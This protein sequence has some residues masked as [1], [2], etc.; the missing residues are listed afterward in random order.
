MEHII[1]MFHKCIISLHQFTWQTLSQ[2]PGWAF[3]SAL[4]NRNMLSGVVVIWGLLLLFVATNNKLEEPHSL[5]E[6]EQRRLQLPA[7]VPLSAG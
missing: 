2:K 4:R 7:A 3:R 5:H 1:Q 6:Y